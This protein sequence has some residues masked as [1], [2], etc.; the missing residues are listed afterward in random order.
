VV[1]PLSVL[2]K[3]DEVEYHL[4]DSDAKAYFCFLGAPKAD[5]C[6]DFFV[7]TAKPTDPSPIEGAKTMGG[8]MH[9]QSPVSE[10]ATT[11]ASDT[12]VIIYTSGTTGRPKGAELTHSNLLQNAILSSDLY[13]PV[14]EDVLLTVLPLFHIP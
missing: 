1:V 14:P 5:K 4:K 9:G 8:L 13:K 2:L 6:Q 12:A 7:I 10:T 11:L 3:R